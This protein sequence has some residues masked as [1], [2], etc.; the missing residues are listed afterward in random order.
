MPTSVPQAPYE[1]ASGLFDSSEPDLGLKPVAGAETF[2]VYAPTQGKD[3]FSNGVVLFPF[4]G[5]LYAQWQSSRRDE[6]SPD[7][8]VAFSVSEDGQRWSE[9]R[10]L[11]S[12]GE[13]GLM[14]SSG[15]W[16]SV[17]ETLVAFINVWPDG[18]LSGAGGYAEFRTS[19]DGETWSSPRRLTGQDGRP[20]E[21]VIEQDPHLIDS[22]LMTAFHM[23]PGMIV[24][25]YY[26]D[27]PLGVS[28]WIPGRMQNLERD[29]SQVGAAHE[30]QLSREI[31][32]SLFQRRDG[33]AV[34]VF[35]DEELSF[36]QL[37]SLSCD[38]GVN[39]TRPA[40][41]AMPDARAKQSA[42]NLPSGDAYLVNAP[43]SDRPRIP[44]AITLSPD[45]REFNRSYLL[46]GRA[47]LQP[48][49]FEG[50]YK[51]P[52]YHYPKSVVWEGWLYVGYAANKEDVQVT[53]LPL[54]SLSSN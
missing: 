34:M 48:L 52:G 50:Q 16:W 39:W 2:T 9:P 31:E 29:L 24:R 47:D 11:A 19:T 35:R 25:P 8:W 36:R 21:G 17:G 54:A 43:N 18:F 40:L 15:G 27:D 33:C 23:R 3:Q 41:T 10:S 6:D 22:R 7:T 4:K 51:R 53:R 13:N 28:G 32:P 49:R 26:T 38:R 30:R 42:G 12:A 1:V 20:I 45:G 14:R 46:R 37:A 5:R 44:L